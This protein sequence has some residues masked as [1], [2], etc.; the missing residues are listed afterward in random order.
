MKI[1]MP[2]KAKHIIET[3]QRAGFEAYIVGGCVR[4][5]LLGREPED[6][7]ITTSAKPWQ[8]KEMF[9]RT[10]DTGI[11]HGTVTVMLDKEGFEVTTYRIDGKYE[12]GRHPREVIFTPSLIE[13][14]KRRD[15]TINA[16]AYNEEGG[17]IDVFG[18]LRD[19]EEK[20]IRCV[21]APK[22]RFSEDA[23]RIM[24]AIRFSAQLGYGIEKRTK[25]AIRVMSP[26]LK[27]ISAERIQVELVKL[28][29]SP[30]PDYL[31]EAYE[32]GVTK[33]ILP[34][35]DQAMDTPQ[36]HPH[37]K[38]NVGEH[39]LAALIQTEPDRILR[40]S[41]LLHD[42]GKPSTLSTDE[43]GVNHFYGHASVGAQM[44][45]KILKRL[46]F[47]NDTISQVSKVVRYHD[48]GN[49]WDPD[50]RMVRRAVNKIGQD[51]FPLLF[52]IKRADIL[53]QSGYLQAEKLER[54]EKWHMLYQEVLKQRQ[55]VSL[56]DLAVTGSDLIALGM[57]PGRKLGEALQ[58]LL[59][60]VM[61]DPELNQKEK[62]LQEAEKYI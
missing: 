27:G 36:N 40:L 53:A 47:D 4:D 34:E 25:E 37:H 26:A 35:F 18:G 33:V 22:E 30:H 61:E 7:D 42:I 32:T 10:I 14:L 38:Y 58:G 21:G 1:E 62:L 60:L 23:L 3:I 57:K 45:E 31:R 48:Y 43:K 16:M 56:K 52:P 9:D 49:E 24:R 46:R 19:M 13:D 12:D 5:S 44:A 55:C 59:E 20:T 2:K 39:T 51:V 41:V 8:I 6:W 28:I 15:F 17:L 54:L 11:Q 50:M 29:I